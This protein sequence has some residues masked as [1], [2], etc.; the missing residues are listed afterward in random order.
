[1]G[2]VAG[3]A[4]LFGFSKTVIASKREEQ[5]LLE[6]GIIEGV[7]LL[8][9]GSSLALRALGW[10]TLYAFL[11]TGTF[12]YGVWKLSGATN[13]SQKSRDRRSCLTYSAFSLKNFAIRWDR[14]CRESARKAHR[15]VG[16]NSRDCPI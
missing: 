9:A 13:V 8:D 3:V 11:G 1:M 7:H 14:F 16:R 5:K 12:G 15:A 10:G 2:S 6:K 4:A